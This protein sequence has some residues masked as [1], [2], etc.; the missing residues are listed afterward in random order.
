MTRS[1]EPTEVEK[2]V[3]EEEGV[4]PLGVGG[5][6]PVTLRGSCAAAA[7]KS[8]CSKGAEREEK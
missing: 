6:S 7:R 2:E 5:T 8:E 3:E 4:D 1:V